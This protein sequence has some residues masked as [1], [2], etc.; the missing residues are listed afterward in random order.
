MSFVFV[1]FRWGEHSWWDFKH[2]FIWAI[3]KYWTTDKSANKWCEYPSHYLEFQNNFFKWAFSVVLISTFFKFSAFLNYFPLPLRVWNNVQVLMYHYILCQ[4]NLDLWL[5]TLA[6]PFSS[7][8]YI[9]ILKHKESLN[10]RS[11]CLLSVCSDCLFHHFER[12][13]NMVKMYI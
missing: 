4:S 3:R 12:G 10:N 9:M 6:H 13:D 5:I 1:G 8:A 7:V 2:W 11:V